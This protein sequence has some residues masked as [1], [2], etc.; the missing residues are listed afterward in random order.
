MLTLAEAASAIDERNNSV[1]SVAAKQ[2]AAM[3]DVLA[4]SLRLQTNC[5]LC[6]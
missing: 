3:S 5:C 4:H 2:V 1:I 6:D